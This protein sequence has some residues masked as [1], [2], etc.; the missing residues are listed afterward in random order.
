MRVNGKFLSKFRPRYML[1]WIYTQGT[2][3]KSIRGPQRRS[4]R[5]GGH[6]GDSSGRDTNSHCHRYGGKKKIAI[7]I[8]VGEFNTCSITL[9]QL[10]GD[11]LDF[12]FLILLK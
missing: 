11:L 12:L 7:N 9:I 1:Q 4:A 6:P 2:K 8:M 10:L 3:S 5:S